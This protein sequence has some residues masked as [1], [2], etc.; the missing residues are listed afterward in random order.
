MIISLTS[1]FFATEVSEILYFDRFILTALFWYPLLTN[2]FTILIVYLVC[3]ISLQPDEK[4]DEN[5]IRP[6]EH[7]GE[8]LSLSVQLKVAEVIIPFFNHN[9]RRGEVLFMHQQISKRI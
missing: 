7:Y 8:S 9:R 6:G 1:D 2:I 4:Y 3:Y 5:A